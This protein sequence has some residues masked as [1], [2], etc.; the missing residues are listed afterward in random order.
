[1]AFVSMWAIHLGNTFF[2]ST[3]DPVSFIARSSVRHVIR[4]FISV[5]YM[6]SEVSIVMNFI[7]SVITCWA[8]TQADLGIFSNSPDTL[9][10]LCM[11]EMTACLFTIVLCKVTETLFVNILLNE[12]AAKNT[13]R[14]VERLLWA[15]ESKPARLQ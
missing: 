13:T 8:W 6:K 9:V 4:A 12:V 15:L 3:T 14:A 7:Q 10:C 11:S 1:M 5:I 2:G